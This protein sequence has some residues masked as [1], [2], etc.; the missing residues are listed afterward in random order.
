MEE[1]VL[2][3]SPG[4]RGLQVHREAG[5]SVGRTGAAGCAAQLGLNLGCGKMC[6]SCV[7]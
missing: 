4:A 3:Q 1:G 7:G 5:A 2:C 6:I